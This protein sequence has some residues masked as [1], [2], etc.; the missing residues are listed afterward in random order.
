MATRT[1]NVGDIVSLTN[2]PGKKYGIVDVKYVLMDMSLDA[3]MAS[4]ALPANYIDVKESD[5]IMTK[6]EGG[7]RRSRSKRR[8]GTRRRRA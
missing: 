5:G 1:F 6:I 3:D 4:T 7:R 2:K 8:A